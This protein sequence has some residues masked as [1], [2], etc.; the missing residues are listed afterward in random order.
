MP[1]IFVCRPTCLP[2]PA[3]PAACVLLAAL[4]Q[5]ST[6]LVLARLEHHSNWVYGV[7]FSPDGK[8]LATG[9]AEDTVYVFAYTGGKV[10]PQP[11]KALQHH[12]ATVRSRGVPQCCTPVLARPATR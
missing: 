1:T 12:T 5:V 7:R 9:G 11:R 3:L 8:Y 6:G 10:E 4:G 2:P